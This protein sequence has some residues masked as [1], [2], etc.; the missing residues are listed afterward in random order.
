MRALSAQLT[1]RRALADVEKW[2]VALTDFSR[3]N[4]DG[5]VMGR[6]YAV[7]WADICPI[8]CTLPMDDHDR[9]L[10]ERAALAMGFW[11]TH[12]EISFHGPV[13]PPA[14]LEKLVQR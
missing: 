12:D 10:L 13:I 8:G 4:Y 7:R 11:L 1:A 3:L 14:I 5:L 6:T 9:G 2:E